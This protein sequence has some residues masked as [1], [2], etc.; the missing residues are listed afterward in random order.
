MSRK[1][2]R[3]KLSQPPPARRE[4]PG[5]PAAPAAGGETRFSRLWPA[6]AALIIAG[7]AML[8]KVD[9]AGRNAWAS[10]SPACLLAG[11][12]LVVPAIWRTFRN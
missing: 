8:L 5:A 11:Y 3:K 1:N 6:S 4:T 9:P 7:Y 10:A 12:L 2:P